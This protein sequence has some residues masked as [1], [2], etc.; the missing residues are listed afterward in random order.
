[1]KRTQLFWFVCACA[2][3]LSQSPGSASDKLQ[4]F[5]MDPSHSDSLGTPDAPVVMVEFTDLEC[6]DCRR[7][8]AQVFQQIKKEFIDTGKVRFISRDWPLEEIHPHAL[9]AAHAA[10]CAGEQGKFW[11]MRDRL[12]TIG[13][14]GKEA[15]TRVAQE[16]SLDT[17]QFQ[18]CLDKQKFKKAIRA[19]VLDAKYFSFEGT[20]AFV[21][22]RPAKN[23]LEG[24]KIEGV[25]SM[26]VF[27][28]KLNELA[29]RQ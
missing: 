15:F 20:P 10:R 3:V 13:G 11:E 23:G 16:L 22:G 18:P 19:D 9:E 1:M 21:V 5:K 6:P 29:R 8:H 4:K 2:L 7:F 14:Q 26:E 12:M 24:Y 28:A 17:A 27:A 25:Q